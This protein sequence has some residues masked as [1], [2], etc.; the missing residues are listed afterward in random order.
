MADWGWP[1]N[2]Q[3]LQWLQKYPTNQPQKL[4]VKEQYIHHFYPCLCLHPCFY[5]QICPQCP[6]PIAFIIPP[7]YLKSRRN[8]FSSARD[9]LENWKRIFNFLLQI[10][11]PVIY[12]LL[13]I[14]TLLHK[15]PKGPR[16]ETEKESI[17]G[18]KR[19]GLWFGWDWERLGV[20]QI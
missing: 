3:R 17:K 16:R 20:F 4:R 7:P 19:K 11:N 8:I 12:S 14:T 6:F 1:N 15:M 10:Q 13:P 18:R 2:S 5:F 9:K